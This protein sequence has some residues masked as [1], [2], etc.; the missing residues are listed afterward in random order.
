M[1]EIE[2]WLSHFGLFLLFCFASFSLVEYFS[3]T[4]G[5]YSFLLKKKEC[6]LW[7]VY[8]AICF[9]FFKLRLSAPLLA[10]THL[11]SFSVYLK[12]LR[13]LRSRNRRSLHTPYPSDV[14]F[15]DE[16]YEE[17]YAA[18]TMV[19]WW[20]NKKYSYWVGYWLSAYFRELIIYLESGW[21]ILKRNYRFYL[22]LHL[23]GI[24]YS[25][26]ARYV[27]Y[28]LFLGFSRVCL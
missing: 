22:L 9:I 16:E 28:W 7:S 25:L 17:G 2:G 15:T 12:H 19:G 26:F 6:L 20:W 27:F 8:T 21:I 4:V 14:V 3:Y 24:F 11:Y 10:V 13:F 18:A 23:T 1:L 5:L